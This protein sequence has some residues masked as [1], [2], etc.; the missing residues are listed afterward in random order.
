MYVMVCTKPELVYIVNIVS[1]FMSNLGKQY[2]KAVKQVLRYMRG[3]ARLS[4]VFHRLKMRKPR[5]LQGYIDADYAGDLD[6]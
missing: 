6:Q 3:T 2:W 5:V 1:P 4:F